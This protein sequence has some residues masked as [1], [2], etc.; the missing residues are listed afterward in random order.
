MAYGKSNGSLKITLTGKWRGHFKDWSTGERG[1]ML[2][3]LMRETGMSYADA[4]AEA[5]KIVSM[6][7]A[8]SIKKTKGHDKLTAESTDKQKKS[9]A[10]A[11]ETWADSS[12]NLRSNLDC[13]A[14]SLA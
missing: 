1:D 11:L 12:S 2:T 4:V 5:A 9:Y 13:P 14:W 3:L 7:E 8:F 10:K 6:P